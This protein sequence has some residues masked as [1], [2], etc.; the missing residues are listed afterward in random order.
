[1]TIEGDGPANGTEGVDV[2]VTAVVP[3]GEVPP[4]R[5]VFG[6]LGT[7][8]LIERYRTGSGAIDGRVLGLAPGHLH[9]E[10]DGGDGCGRWSCSAVLGHIADAE[11]VN[12][13]RMRR[14]MAEEGPELGNW[15]E[16]GFVSRGLYGPATGG[17]GGPSPGGVA[18]GRPA[19]GFV[20]MVHTTRLWMGQYLAT[21][22]E[23]DWSRVGLHGV[24]GPL[25][26]RALLERT[27]WHLEHHAWF[28]RRKL[29]VLLG[30]GVGGSGAAGRPAGGGCGPGCGCVG[31]G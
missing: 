9:R 5:E 10:F 15:D 28:L 14:V 23:A 19:G 3:A 31:R 1:M 27:V 22:P 29:D 18:G 24:E 6:D 7:L 25:S 30:E 21:V 20:A 8:A 17:V 12:A 4:C 16:E 13:M 26:L 11:M 2:G